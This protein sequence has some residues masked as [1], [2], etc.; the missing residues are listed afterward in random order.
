MLDLGTLKIGIQVDDQEAKKELDN[1][2]G[3]VESAG[4][5]IKSKLAGAAKIAK[6]ASIA[7]I[8]E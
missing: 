1:F 2:T 5:S 8:A 6:A 3:E 4:S 7:A